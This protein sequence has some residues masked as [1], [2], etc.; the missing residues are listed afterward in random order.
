MKPILET[1]KN[2]NSNI[3]S[4]LFNQTM[5]MATG[6]TRISI[7]AGASGTHKAPLKLSYPK[8]SS[9]AISANDTLT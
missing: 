9:G 8:V 1:Q 7:K 3:V 6:P 5:Y 4:S 2:E